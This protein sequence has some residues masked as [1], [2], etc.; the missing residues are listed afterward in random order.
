MTSTAARPTVPP[1][2]TAL[3]SELVGTAILL[4]TVV[5]SGVM[6]DTLCGGNT[7]LALLC[8]ALATGGALIALISTFGAFS[9]AHFN[10]VVSAVAAI[11]G[12]LPAARLP[13]YLLAQVVGALAGVACAH[14]MFALPLVQASTHVR[15]TTGEVFS[16]VVATFGLII[17]ILGTVRNAPANIAYAVAGYIVAAYWFTQ[18]T[19]F[20]NPAVTL[21]R[22]FSDTFAGIAPASVGA[23]VIAQLIGAALALGT[24]GMLERGDRR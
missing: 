20:A 23:F 22:S 14:V 15:S 7:G 3:L 18:S 19:S 4:A 9:G 11:R 17:T 21:A 6:A 5:G 13:G 24:F 12:D 10:P 8:N 1:I 16:E 2:T